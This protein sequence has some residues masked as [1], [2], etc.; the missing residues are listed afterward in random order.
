MTQY[1]TDQMIED[2]V[3]TNLGETVSARQKHVYREALRGLV[4]LAKAEQLHAM[5]SDVRKLTGDALPYLHHFDE[6]K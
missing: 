1:S 2:M 4:R 6:S 3:A 5:K